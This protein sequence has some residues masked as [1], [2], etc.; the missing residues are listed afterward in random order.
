M[1]GARSTLTQSLAVAAAVA[2]VVTGAIVLGSAPSKPP[3]PA[4]TTTA[5]AAPDPGQAQ[6]A[7]P[8]VTLGAAALKLA[9]PLRV[10]GNPSI[11]GTGPSS[12]PRGAIS[13]PAGDDS[14]V[15]WSQAHRTY[16]FAPG[17]H[18]LGAGQYTQILPANGS[19]FVGAPGAVITGQHDNAY[20]FGGPAE[21]VTISYLTIEDFGTSGGNQNEGVVNHDSATGWRIDH[22][23]ITEN[24]GAGVMLGSDNELT[25]D[26]LED[27]QQYGFNAYSANGP[28]N[29]VLEH[30]EI[31][32]NDTY[33]WEKRDPG[34]G[35]TGG[36]K[37]W[38]VDGATIRYNWIYQNHSVGIWADTNN[39]GFDIE[40]NYFEGNYDDGLVYEISYNAL[41]RAN[42]FAR[43]GLGQGPRNQGFP[44]GAIYVSESGSDARVG[45]K[46]SHV[47]DITGNQFIDNWSGV[48]LW[49]NANRFCDSP[50]N[51]STG[52]CTLVDPA[53][54]NIHGCTS[55][56]LRHARSSRSPD[57]FDLCRWKT[58]NV[59][60]TQ[61]VFDFNP[62]DLGPAC[63]VA[64]GC[65][66]VGVFSNWGSDP[67]WSPYQGP[68]IE[69]RIA[70]AQNNHFAENAYRGPW[71]FMVRG[72][73]TIVSWQEW[74][75]APYHQDAGSTLRS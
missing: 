23:S 30:N 26:C 68:V 27:N 8:G 57:Y 25:Y 40:H 61:N 4:T 3:Q 11:L 50:D 47:F 71:R 15:N 64:N 19:T 13:V 62:A 42:V 18:T 69:D 53:V 36:G 6:Q 75:Q 73:G 21:N 34:C 51:S 39:R 9:S 41:V 38:S 33:N 31:A 24:A 63:T 10:C 43:N 56:T 59:S 17:V 49:E 70:L 35:C 48:I 2:A 1:G 32:G 44:D 16:W 14:R 5:G 65:G 55:Q 67:S 52:F 12:P 22:S 7:Q 28:Q 66:F 74:R 60:V 72:L 58:Q 29:L 45:S 37:F 46:Y 54:A 20:A